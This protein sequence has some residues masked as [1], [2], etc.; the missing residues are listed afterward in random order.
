MT[1]Q[2]EG[3]GSQLRDAEARD[4]LPHLTP[5][6]VLRNGLVELAE[7]MEECS[8]YVG[9]ERTQIQ[10]KG[11]DKTVRFAHNFINYYRSVIPKSFL[12]SY[13]NPCWYSSISPDTEPLLTS[14]DNFDSTKYT[15]SY[16]N[17]LKQSVF[18]KSH[19]KNH[20]LCLPYFFIAGFP[21]SA[22][23]NLDA[24]LRRHNRIVGP[25]TKEPHWWTRGL[26][27][28]GEAGEELG[29]LSVARYPLFFKP[30]SDA[31][32][33][34]P[35]TELITYDGSQSTLWDSPVL[36]EGLDYCVLPAV[37]SQ[38]LPNAKFIIL[39]RDP[40]DRLISHYIWSCKYHRGSS[41]NKWPP[42]ILENGPTVLHKQAVELTDW[43]ER[44]TQ[45][46]SLYECVGEK[47]LHIT[48]N[49]TNQCG[50]IG[51]RLGIGLYHVH[52]RKW[53]HFFPKEQFLF[54]RMED[55]TNNPFETMSKITNFLHISPVSNEEADQW[56]SEKINHRTHE[57]DTLFKIRDT[58]ISLLRNFY[59]PHNELLAQLLGDDRF[60]WSD[61]HSDVL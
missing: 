46:F 1:T 54:L 6:V 55:L 37:M 33:S 17:K 30:L 40:V 43:F 42:E 49:I 16:L 59:R 19:S 20:L 13:K 2:A 32:E 45:S 41:V 9:I 38:L 25:E 58:T 56:F 14:L 5:E 27:T 35:D 34:S 60:L 53:L 44:C 18:K 47:S 61:I 36:K 26:H 23:T 50:V 22:T 3:K 4:T 8:V 57:Q 51:H 29:S 24:G 28:K 21:K 52:I 10:L 48:S 39:M 7:S 31:L 15:E 12:R 11:F